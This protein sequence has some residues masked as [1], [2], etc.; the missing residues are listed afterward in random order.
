VIALLASL[1]LFAFAWLL[2]L[3]WWRFKAPRQPRPALIAV[4]A[5]APLLAL[6]LWL[7]L[8]GLLPL[9]PSA[10]PA[11]IV[12]Y[13]GAA[14]CYLI[15]YEGVEQTSPSLMIIRAL[16]AAGDGGCSTE[17]LAALFTDELLLR[18]RLELMR[19]DHLLVAVNGGHVL[20]SRGRRAALV[21]SF[22]SRLFNIQKAA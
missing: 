8:F 22:L 20:T 17:E 10:W 11:V 5:V 3:A 19:R 4:F 16:A 9:V 1:A 6:G 15:A 12:S 7:A 14:F 21:A 18:P 13:A 2:H